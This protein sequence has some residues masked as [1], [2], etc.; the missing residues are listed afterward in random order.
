MSG[1]KTASVE[2]FQALE[3]ACRE[4]GAMFIMDEVQ[5]GVGR[6]G[7]FTY[8]DLLGI[9]PDMITLAKSLG[10]GVPV[11][12]VLVRDEGC[13]NGASWGARDHVW[14]WHVGYGCR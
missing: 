4:T 6:T 14:R 5:T 12:A 7:A 2:Y 1:M 8:A 11:A 13:S 9:K 3:S 10:G